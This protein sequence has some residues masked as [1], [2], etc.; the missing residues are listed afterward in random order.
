MSKLASRWDWTTIFLY[1]IF[2]FWGW[3]AIYSA[4][5]KNTDASIFNLN[6][7]FGKQL[8]WIV[9]ALA[10]GVVVLYTDTKFIEFVAPGVYV[11][12]VILM[13]ITAIWGKEINGAKAWLEIGG[14]RL[15]SSEFGKVGT[16]LFLAAY[17][18]RYNFSFKY[19]RHRLAVFAI[20]ALPFGLTMMQK[21]TG[22]ALVFTSF[23]IMLY[24]EGLSAKYLLLVL[25]VGISAVLGLV[26]NPVLLVSGIALAALM[27]YYFFY[28]KKFL[29]VHVALGVL[30]CTTALGMD[31]IVDRVL[32]PHQ[33][34]R[35]YAA[36]NPEIDPQGL[37]W[38]T[39]QSKIAIGSGG[40]SGKG[41]LQ[42]TQTKFDFV[43]QQDTDFIFCTI[44]EETGWLGSALFLVLM[45]AFLAQL[46]YLAENS[47]S[48]FARVFGYGTV[49]I[50][51][52]HLTVNIGMTIGLIPVIGIP[53]PFFSYGGSS[54]LSFTLMVFI[55]LN[56]YANRTNVLS[57]RR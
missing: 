50:L 40:F 26:T 17:M 7:N 10:A 49:S 2:V 45:F 33:R 1:L 56:F 23:L 48:P 43:P 5:V 22:T 54:L 18:S 31:Y 9:L 34:N 24:R 27:S 41:F 6:F 14:I 4:S 25:G 55:L 42:G 57:A 37:N 47:K 15:Q 35:I 46:T 8:I 38:N 13:T 28:S 36:L 20:V 21:D 51:F 29:W 44:G 11:A 19:W 39:L 30:F 53:L 32:K 3:V 52:F 12:S 16:S